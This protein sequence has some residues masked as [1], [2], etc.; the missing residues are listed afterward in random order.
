MAWALSQIIVI[1]A[2]SIKDRLHTEPFLA[3]YDIM[4]RNAF[5]NYRDILR[6]ISFSPVMGE[7]LSYLNSKSSSYMFQE[8]NLIVYP[9]ENFAREI[10]QLFTI[11]Y[12]HLNPDGTNLEDSTSECIITYTNEEIMEYSRVWTGFV[13]N[14]LR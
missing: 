13:F 1:A 5:S 7:N 10:M 14:K 4:V 2:P 6:E 8:T 12:C 11:G 3:Y 9:D